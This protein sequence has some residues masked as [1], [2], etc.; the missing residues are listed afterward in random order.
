[1]KNSSQVL[2][3]QHDR[4]STVA[5]GIQCILDLYA[6]PATL[7]NDLGFIEQ[8]LIQAAQV[9]QSTLL[10]KVE[11]QFSPQGV[12]ALALLAESHIAIHTWPERGYAAVDIFTCGQH[13]QPEAACAYLTSALQAGDSHLVKLPRQMRPIQL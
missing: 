13:T 1:M 8:A 10:G 5:V 4:T 2:P 9:S 6:C 12:T 3:N 11:Y 7:L